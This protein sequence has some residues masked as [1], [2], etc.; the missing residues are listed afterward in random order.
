M[1]TKVLVAGTA[2][3]SAAVGAVG[4][5]LYAKKLLA[6]GYAEIA[7]EEIEQARDHYAKLYKRDEYESPEQVL[8][9]RKPGAS[10]DASGRTISEV[11]GPPSNWRAVVPPVP[12]LERVV[13]G[14]KKPTQPDGEGP[15]IITVEEYMAG[16]L[17]YEQVT[18]TW[19][20]PDQT[21]A[22][23]ADD[24]VD[25]VDTKIGLHHMERFGQGSKDKNTVYIRNEKLSID[26]E[27]VRSRQSL[28]EALGLDDEEDED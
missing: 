15:Y 1:N 3:V 20:E 28:R 9:K 22:D 27:V 23:E 21:I 6:D 25:D 16:D 26:Y 18:L 14:L 12:I 4:G 8:A 7:K 2:L 17:G 10:K 13:K 19:Y 11:D 5:F 24:I